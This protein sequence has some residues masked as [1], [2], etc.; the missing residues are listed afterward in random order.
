[1]ENKKKL[2]IIDGNALVHRAFHALPPLTNKK[3][4]IVNAVYGFL[5]VLFR[6]IKDIKPEYIVA[7]FDLPGPTF[8]HQQYEKYKITRPKTPEG[9]ISQL[10]KV[11]EVLR[12]FNIAIFEKQGFEA[13]D[14]IATI[15]DKVS[16]SDL[17]KEA[18]TIILS[19][20]SDTLQMVDKNTKV[21]FIKR[22]V[23]ETI[24][25][26]EEEV[27]KK[28]DGLSS[29]Q[30]ADFKSL[31]GDASDNIPGVKGIGE[32]GAIELL[33]KFGNLENIYKAIEE[34]SE[35]AKELKEKTKT[36]LLESKEN[37]IM[38]K[39]LAL[40]EKNVPIEFDLR[41]CQWQGYD[42]EKASAALQELGFNS[43]LGRLP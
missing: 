23:T 43:L 15:A 2:V 20:D 21:C 29:S 14:V 33:K 13:D 40:S 19:A 4:E 22:G 24:L 10:P 12:S 31:K 36:L 34:N 30:V 37:A 39:A 16:N 42:K 11:K 8:R 5:L 9:I 25:Y 27:K 26:D 35:A 32:K 1:M 6:A 38:S 7:T 41:F 17:S 18:E 3:G 28:F